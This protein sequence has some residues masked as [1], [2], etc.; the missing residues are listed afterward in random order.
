MQ[1]FLYEDYVRTEWVDYNKHMNDAAYATAFSLAGEQLLEDI[2][3]NEEGRNRHHYTIFTLESHIVYLKEAH[4]HERLLAD[5]QWIDTDEKRLHL[6]YTLYNEE[7]ERIA[8]C[9]Q[10]L[11]GM[12]QETNRPAPF[13]EDIQQAIT[14][15]ARQ[16]QDKPVPKEVGRTIGIKKK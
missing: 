15:K 9:E 6:F 14:A 11:M 12:S 4:E 13:P 2:G 7:K 10:M 3:L 8:V 16:D 5:V 1:S